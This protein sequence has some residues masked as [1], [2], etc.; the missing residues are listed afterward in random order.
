MFFYLDKIRLDVA[1]KNNR[2]RQSGPHADRIAKNEEFIKRSNNICLFG[3]ATLTRAPKLLKSLGVLCLKWIT[4]NG[5]KK[6]QVE[7]ASESAKTAEMCDFKKFF[8][9]HCKTPAQN[10]A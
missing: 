3:S 4:R 7:Y 2:K 1:V 6:N 8:T 5:Q 10:P 9:F